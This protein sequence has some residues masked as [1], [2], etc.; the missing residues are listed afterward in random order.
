MQM[1]IIGFFGDQHT[2]G[3]PMAKLSGFG[4]PAPRQVTRPGARG[5]DWP[6]N[7]RL[8][9]GAVGLS[10]GIEHDCKRQSRFN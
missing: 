2:C 8:E 9:A 5:R 10:G 3:I 1:G 6:T 4:A 7:A